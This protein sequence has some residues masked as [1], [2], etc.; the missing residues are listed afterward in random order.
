MSL[1]A[2]TIEELKAMF[3]D[4]Y[5]DGTVTKEKLAKMFGWLENPVDDDDVTQMIASW[6]MGGYPRINLNDF[7]N[8]NRKS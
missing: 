7:L 2:A 8:A 6:N 5:A 1:S 4:E 3:I